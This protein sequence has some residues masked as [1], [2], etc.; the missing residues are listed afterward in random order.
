MGI[1]WTYRL[2]RLTFVTWR[3]LPGWLR[4]SLRGVLRLWSRRFGRTTRE[5]HARPEVSFRS[6]ASR[7][8]IICFPIVDWEMR[9][10]RPQQLLARLAAKGYRV[11]YVRKDFKGGRELGQL[12]IAP[13]ITGIALPGRTE[14]NIYSGTPTSGDAERWLAALASLRP[15]CNGGPVV[16]FV[17]W[18]FWA[19]LALTAR[20]RWNW[21][22]L[23]DC[24]DD[25]AGFP[26]AR[27]AL[28]ELEQ[29]LIRG[30]DLTLA[31]SQALFEK[32]EP[33]ARRCQALG[34][35]GDFLH[36]SEPPGVACSTIYVAAS[37][38]T[39]ARW[40]SGSPRS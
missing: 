23:Y 28:L 14:G 18:P 26:A 20:D 4:F 21:K 16:S 36:F 9:I 1:S 27:P 3:R 32:C 7:P 11:L 31:T 39:T 34:N 17:Q 40:P 2:Q 12:P 22:V 33:V 13:G 25:H 8:T 5:G 6:D 29:Q 15:S 37:W 38:A 19:D 10:Q 30:S 35:A 24:L